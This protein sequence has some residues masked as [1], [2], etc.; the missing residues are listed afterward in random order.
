MCIGMRNGSLFKYYNTS[1]FIHF[2]NPL[3]K[4][5][6]LFIFLIMILMCSSIRVLCGLSFILFYIMVISNISFKEYFRVIWVFRYLLIILF[7]INLFFGF[8]FDFIL[9]SR[10]CLCLLYFS[11]FFNTTTFDDIFYG[12][13]S[14]FDP[15]KIFGISVFNL[16]LRFSLIMFFIPTFFSEYNRICK[17]KSSRGVKNFG[18]NDYFSSFI[19]SI[20]MSIRGVKS[21]GN[22][23]MIRSFD[24]NSYG[25]KWHVSD[26]YMISCHLLVLIFVLIK[27][28]VL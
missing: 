7:F 17:S 15:F 19:S 27:E 6:G 1:S 4:I 26:F 9:I 12:F 20:F 2:L 16:S 28:V 8:Y 5:L 23:I 22:V 11:V 21:I 3:C 13:S 25:F 24:N 18:L 10:I 14:L